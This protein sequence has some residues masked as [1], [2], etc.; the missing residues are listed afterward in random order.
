[1]D[2]TQLESDRSAIITARGTGEGLVLRIDGRVGRESL[3]EALKEFVASRRKFLSGNDVALEWV[4]ESP[5]EGF[6]DELCGSLLKEYEIKVRSSRM[7]ETQRVQPPAD[8]IASEIEIVQIPEYISPAETRPAPRKGGE[9]EYSLFDGMEALGFPEAEAPGERSNM[10][11]DSMMW[12]EPDARAVYST[13]RSG[14]KIETEHSL[15]I[16]GD[17]NSGGEVIAG[18]DIVVL[19]TL[20]GIA[21]AGAYDE[22]GGGRFIVALNLQPTQLRIGSVITRGVTDSPKDGAKGAEIARVEG[23]TVVVE[24]YQSRGLF[25][26]GTRLH[27]GR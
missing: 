6:V 10:A 13:V 11:A 17:V 1:M 26:R 24:P 9:K 3:V 18:G 25:Q 4:G 22:T 7:K 16:F 12:D 23:N 14:Q 21:H 20:R 8:D 2:T 15:V 5:D 19:G 27:G